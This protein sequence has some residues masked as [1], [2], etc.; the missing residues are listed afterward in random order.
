MMEENTEKCEKSYRRGGTPPPP[1][2]DGLLQRRRGETGVGSVVFWAAAV[3]ASGVASGDPGGCF[4][5]LVYNHA[6]RI[7]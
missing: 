4:S 2:A 7:F 6:K 3:E 5:H 1:F